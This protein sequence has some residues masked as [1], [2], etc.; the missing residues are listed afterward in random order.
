MWPL[1]E[2]CGYDRFH[3]TEQLDPMR[4]T[5]GFNAKRKAL[6]WMIPWRDPE[7]LHASD[8]SELLEPIGNEVLNLYHG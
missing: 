2:K 6:P 8:C 5:A 3:L 7:A 4:V 1:Q